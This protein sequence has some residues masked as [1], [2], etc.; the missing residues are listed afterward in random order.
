MIDSVIDFA[1]RRRWVVVTLGVIT[2]AFGAFALTRLPIDAVP[3]ITNKQVQ[4][5]SIAPALSPVE[6]EKQITF[7]IETAL[8]GAPGLESTRSLSRNGFSQITA[9]FTERTD[10]YF[11]RQQI[12]ERL[13]DVRARLP[14]GIEPRIGPISTGLGKTSTWPVLSPDRPAERDGAPGLQRDGRFLTTEGQLL[15]GEI[16]KNA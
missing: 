2:A 8:A 10:I 16:E 15:E 5:N 11:A 3:D 9:I 12:G 13:N 4:I 1:I 14:H 6:I 7:P